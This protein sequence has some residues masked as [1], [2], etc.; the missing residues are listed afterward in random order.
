M[1]SNMSIYRRLNPRLLVQV[2]L[3]LDLLYWANISNIYISLTHFRQHVIM[4]TWHPMFSVYQLQIH[5]RSYSK[6]YISIDSYDIS[7]DID[8]VIN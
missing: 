3:S 4:R 8:T 2:G 1:N 6:L 5:A 7:I